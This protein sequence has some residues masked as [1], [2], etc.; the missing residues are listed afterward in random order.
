MEA[1]SE[2]VQEPKHKRLPAA[3]II[4]E[5][6]KKKPSVILLRAVKRIP[7]RARVGYI[8]ILSTAR[9]GILQSVPLTTK[10]K[11]GMKIINDNGLRFDKISLGTPCRVMTAA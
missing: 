3:Q 4:A 6:A 10:S 11:I 9:T 1:V 5:E 2:G 7:R 8:Y